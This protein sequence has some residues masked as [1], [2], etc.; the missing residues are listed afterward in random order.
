MTSSLLGSACGESTGPRSTMSRELGERAHDDVGM[1]LELPLELL[2]D[3]LHEPF[4]ILEAARIARMTL[5]GRCRTR[6]APSSARP[7]SSSFFSV[8][9]LR[10]VPDVFS[11]FS[12][13]APESFDRP[14][15]SG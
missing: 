5:P 15:P 12:M 8:F 10:A 2:H 14:T 1:Q 9:Q 6:P 3:A 7:V 13:T 11:L 4:A